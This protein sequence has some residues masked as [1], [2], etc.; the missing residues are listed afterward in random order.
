MF[1]LGL[2]YKKGEGVEQD[3]AQATKWFRAAALQGESSAMLN[4][5]RL[6]E[7]GE[8]VEKDL[9]QAYAYYKVAALD[10]GDRDA[11]RP[12]AQLLKTSSFT[13][14]AKG[15]LTALGLKAD[16]AAAKKAAK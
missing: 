5:G 12:L 3:L 15:D 4:L 11:R 16:I 1:N 10:Y 13:F 14:I 6:Y 7:K 9:A 2:S 8:G